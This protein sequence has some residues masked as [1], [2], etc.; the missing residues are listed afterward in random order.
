[1]RGQVAFPGV[2]STVEPG[3]KLM[4]NPFAIALRF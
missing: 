2:A 1:V 3:S 4:G